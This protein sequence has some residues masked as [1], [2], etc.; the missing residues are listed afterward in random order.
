VLGWSKPDNAGDSNIVAIHRFF[1]PV[2][3]DGKAMLA[4]LT[5]KE[6]ADEVTPN[7][8]YS[9]ESVEFNE[10]TP[11]AQWVAASANADSVSLTSIRSARD[12]QSLAQEVEDFNP[13]TVSKVVDE[14]GEPQVMYHGTHAD[15]NTFDRETLD[16]TLR[17]IGFHFTSDT[18]RA[19]M[20]AAGG[21]GG[22][23]IPVYLNIRNPYVVEDLRAFNAQSNRKYGKYGAEKLIKDFEAKGYDGLKFDNTHYIAFRPEQIKSATGNKGNFDPENPDIR[24]SRT[25]TKTQGISKASLVEHTAKLMR[26]W[27]NRPSVKILARFEDL[28]EAIKDEALKASDGSDIEGVYWKGTVYLVAE[29]IE[30]LERAETVI[31]HEILGHYG[32]RK[33]LGDKLN[34]LLNQVYLAYGKSGLEDI[35][36]R[37]GLDL[38][39]REGRLTAAEEK[40]AHM[41]QTGERPGIL[42]QVYA[43][44]RDWIRRMG[45]DLKLNNADLALLIE[46]S[47]RFVEHGRPARQAIG[48]TLEPAFRR[49]SRFSRASGTEHQA[50]KRWLRVP[51]TSPKLNQVRDALKEIISGKQE[52]AIKD[53]RPD[54]EQ[55][56]GDADVHFQWG[57]T[58]LGLMHIG[59]KRGA[60][61]LIKVV[62]AA[63]V[64][65]RMR[66]IPAK[67]TVRITHNGITAVLSLDEHGKQKTW[68]LTG[69]EE[70]KPDARGEVSAQ[71][72]ATQST[73]TFSRDE[74]GAGFNSIVGEFGEDANSDIRF[75]RRPAEIFEDIQAQ[76]ARRPTVGEYVKHKIEDWRP[77]WLGAL[78]RLHLA[79]V[80]KGIL[81]QAKSYVRQAQQMDA[82][83]NH[84]LSESAEIAQHWGKYQRKFKAESAKLSD[85]MHDAT[86]AGTDPA[87]DFKPL[88]DITAAQ[89]QLS[90]LE[91]QIRKAGEGAKLTG[92][93][94]KQEKL[95]A[96]LRE[97][98][99][100]IRQYPL[101]KTRYQALSS[102]GKALYKAVRDHYRDR[103]G[104]VYQA[105]ADRIDRAQVSREERAKLK[106]KLRLRFESAQVTA[107]Y[108]PLAR[109]GDYWVQVKDG[110]EAGFYMF[111]SA[112]AQ[113]RFARQQQAKGHEVVAGK[114]LENIKAVHGASEGFLSDVMGILD[115]AGIPGSSQLKD[116]LYQLYLSTLPELSARKHFIHRKKTKGYSQD[117]LRAFA[118]QTFHGAYQL[119]RLKHSDILEREL[120]TMRQSIPES[121][122]PNKATDLYNEFLKRHEW[123]MNPRGSSWSAFASSLGFAWYLGLT[124]AAAITNLTQT[125][126]VAFPVLGSRHGWGKA[127]RALNRAM[128]DYFRGKFNAANSPAVRT[129]FDGDTLKALHQLMD[130]GV[131][132]RT[133]SHD[134][135]G[136]GE[137]DSRVYNNRHAQIMHGISFMFHQAE[138]FNREVTA[139]AAYRLARAAGKTHEQAVGEA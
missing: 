39:T 68:L 82:D 38:N 13:K 78:T 96:R 24:F 51:G 73:P 100:R 41:A 132:D 56:G 46:K 8:L 121:S 131:L 128:G 87:E 109:F 9:V 22:N 138:V 37:Y 103:S 26:G 71:S 77:G 64:G 135:A 55:Y 106:A 134:L 11:A 25:K 44:L 81:P 54:L 14:S 85:L 4:K 88:L 137:T 59:E 16:P 45:F 116:T 120:E 118:K 117:A 17:G 113:S 19:N 110:D 125:P 62:Y 47:A 92:L 112:Q 94:T 111:E 52:V 28:P 69:W 76:V 123:I 126:L 5:V 32:L 102:E 70:G 93:K 107:P 58:K 86:V 60:E 57:N 6:M 91:R 90:E 89:Q 95:K 67:K 53:L 105:L 72:T 127:S 65:Q 35:A 97:E 23:I 104:A 99:A 12:I 2:V 3:R 20:F 27:K 74:L 124:P 1:T 122:D 83:R 40:L 115:E 139:L 29:N 136:M 48:M 31:F 63:A 15:F 18:Q 130:E 10:K 133:L 98:Q 43:L 34:P 61:V 36:K 30:S 84:L 42:R 49:E 79:D 114:S 119:A 101:L 66:H 108:F 80:A 7:R 50:F 129:E 33:T 21:Q 75:S